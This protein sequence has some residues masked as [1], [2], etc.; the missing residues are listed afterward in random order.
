LQSRFGEVKV[1]DSQLEMAREANTLWP[2]EETARYLA[3]VALEAK[4]QPTQVG[5]RDEPPFGD[6]GVLPGNECEPAI[7]EATAETVTLPDAI[8]SILVS[9]FASTLAQELSTPAPRGT[10]QPISLPNA[11]ETWPL[12][13]DPV[14][15]PPSQHAAFDQDDV[16]LAIL[17]LQSP[18]ETGADTETPP[19]NVDIETQAATNAIAETGANRPTKAT[20]RSASIVYRLCVFSGAA[21][22]IAGIIVVMSTRHV[23]KDASTAQ[24]VAA[25]AANPRNQGADAKNTAPQLAAIAADTVHSQAPPVPHPQSAPSPAAIARAVPATGG[26]PPQPP[27]AVRPQNGV[28]AHLDATPVSELSAAV[29]SPAATL[30]AGPSLQTPEAPRAESGTGP[31]GT[32]PSPVAQ[33][34][35]T[36]VGAAPVLKTESRTAPTVNAQTVAA[37]A[38]P[39]PQ[40]PEAPHAQDKPTSLLQSPLSQAPSTQAAP[41]PVEPSAHA[42]RPSQAQGGAAIVSEP[43]APPPRVASAEVGKP[44]VSTPEPPT[45]AASIAKP[46]LGADE[47]EALLSRSSGFLKNGDFAAAR[48]LLR[49]AAESG[50]AEAALML[51][52]TFDPLY[53][54]ELGAMGIRPDIAQALEWYQK[55]VQLGSEVAAQRLTQLTQI[56]E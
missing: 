42:P 43:Q 46:P 53:L 11:H 4:L 8:D 13:S 39:Q 40:A 5:G 19:P 26:P 28:S 50:S 16:A 55:A 32:L 52:K 23:A 14:V 9:G 2:N 21:A 36:R 34:A 20:G 24:A 44:P 49:R 45:K 15:T 51:G 22:L 3:T 18:L 29:S 1:L 10:E 56:R 17:R 30:A 47:L 25:D 38:E 27:T 12:N 48:I 35:G 31:V 54:N 7:D 33:A 37:A 41:A 6:I